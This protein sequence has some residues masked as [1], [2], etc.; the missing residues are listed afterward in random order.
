MAQYTITRSCGHTES[1]QIYG[2]NSHGERERKAQ[3]EASK[4]CAECYK[5][6]LAQER[7]ASAEAGAQVAAD[8]GLAPLTGSDKQVAWANQIRGKFLAELDGIKAQAAAAGQDWDSPV[9][10]ETRALVDKVLA[11]TDSSWW[12]D[13]RSKDLRQMLIMVRDAA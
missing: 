11:H 5:A 7:Q 1:V 9:A 6:Q 10:A 8:A 12:I 3:Y 13:N 4:A 2:T